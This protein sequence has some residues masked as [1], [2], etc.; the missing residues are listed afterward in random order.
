M[1]DEHQESLLHGR[2][3]EGNSLEGSLE[4]FLEDVLCYGT[5]DPSGPLP[6]KRRRTLAWVHDFAA[7]IPGPPQ[8]RVFRRTRRI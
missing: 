3:P 6:Q 7:A 8:L 2:R 1:A 5:N 4:N